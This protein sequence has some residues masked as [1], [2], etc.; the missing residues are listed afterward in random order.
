MGI[1]YENWLKVMTKLVCNSVLWDIG[2][3]AEVVRRIC[4]KRRQSGIG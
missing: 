3:E 4:N 1:A 2:M